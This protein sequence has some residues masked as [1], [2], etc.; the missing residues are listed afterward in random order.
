MLNKF[1][2]KYKY[3]LVIL[4]FVFFQAL[5]FGIIQIFFVGNF[6]VP[7]RF[8]LH[9]SVFAVCLSFY[10]FMLSRNDQKPNLVFV[11][12][13][14]SWEIR[15]IGKGAAL[16]ICFSCRRRKSTN[17]PNDLFTEWVQPAI[18]IDLIESNQKFDLENSIFE[19]GDEYIAIYSDVKG[20]T[21]SS[22]YM[23]HENKPY[24]SNA[25]LSLKKEHAW[26]IYYYREKVNRSPKF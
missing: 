13:G 7:D 1:P 5:T 23:N 11:N 19:K 17:N 25:F 16:S 6:S 10:Q 22:S 8:S 20:S 9:L 24:L 18:L 2:K 21:Y 4:A 14:N 3:F 26:P 12:M 15:N